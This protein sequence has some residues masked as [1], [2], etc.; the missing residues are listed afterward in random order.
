MQNWQWVS[1]LISKTAPSCQLS[2]HCM[3]YSWRVII[4]GNETNQPERREDSSRIV[5]TMKGSHLNMIIMAI[6]LEGKGNLYSQTTR[7]D[8]QF[9]LSI[10]K[11]KIPRKERLNINHRKIWDTRMYHFVGVTLFLMSCSLRQSLVFPGQLNPHHGI[12][13]FVRNSDSVSRFLIKEWSSWGRMF[14]ETTFCR[15]MNENE[16]EV[17]GSSSSSDLLFCN[18]IIKIKGCFRFGSLLWELPLVSLKMRD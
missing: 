12:E 10:K 2:S 1:S 16:N 7:Q 6:H 18:N 14:Y 11:K 8:Q 5:Y 4:R 9:P 13:S 3:Q 15:W 17:Q